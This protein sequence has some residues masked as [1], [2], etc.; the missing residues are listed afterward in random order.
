VISQTKL[1]LPSSSDGVV[2]LRG[3]VYDYYGAAAYGDQ[4]GIRV[5]Y[6]DSSTAISVLDAANSS[7]R[8]R[9][10]GDEGIVGDISECSSLASR[11]ELTNQLLQL[12]GF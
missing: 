6:E 2:T 8:F 7:L 11:D 1:P 12:C 4:E 5:L 10:D 9:S 3:Y